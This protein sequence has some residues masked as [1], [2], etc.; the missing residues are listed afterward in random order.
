[1]ISSVALLIMKERKPKP[2]PTASGPLLAEVEALGSS[3]EAAL[4]GSQ[5]RHPAIAT[6]LTILE[7]NKMLLIYSVVRNEF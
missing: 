6:G 2:Y 1:M 7:A 5:E 3:P 4:D